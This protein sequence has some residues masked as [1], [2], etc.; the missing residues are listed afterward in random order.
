MPVSTILELRFSSLAF[1]LMFRRGFG[2]LISPV[3]LVLLSVCLSKFN[4]NIISFALL[5]F[6]VPLLRLVTIVVCLRMNCQVLYHSLQRWILFFT[7]IALGHLEQ[8]IPSIK[9]I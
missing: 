9:K 5:L 3:L 6:S 4:C 8:N 7:H 2:T 1:W